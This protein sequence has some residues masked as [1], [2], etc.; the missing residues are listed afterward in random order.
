MTD[1]ELYHFGVKGMKWGVR[2]K[3]GMSKRQVKSAIR[4]A[5][6]NYRRNDNPY[7]T[8]DG[9]TGKNWADVYSKHKQAV[10]NDKSIKELRS[11]RDSMYKKA[12]SADRRGNIEK[13]NQ[14][15][16]LGDSFQDSIT[17]RKIEVGKSFSNDYSDALLKDIGYSN[18]EKGRE[19]LK[20]YG[21]TNDYGRYK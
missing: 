18:I 10:D 7:H 3:Y 11:K 6:R 17:K 14:Y 15:Q 1:N 5:K 13:S 8:F 2:K 21:I 4:K 9:T 16:A 19:M 20:E 12:E